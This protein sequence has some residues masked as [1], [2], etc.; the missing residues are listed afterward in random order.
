MN[1]IDKF[2][3]EFCCI[4]AD[5]DECM[6]GTDDCVQNCHDTPGSYNCSCNPGY[7]LNTDGFSCNGK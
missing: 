5:D 4:P 7:S 3:D 6:L 2:A 1:A